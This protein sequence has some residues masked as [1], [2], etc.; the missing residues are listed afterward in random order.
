MVCYGKFSPGFNLYFQLMLLLVFEY[1]TSGCDTLMSNRTNILRDR[2]H[3]VRL[4]LSLVHKYL[5]EQ[6]KISGDFFPLEI[7][8]P[9]LTSIATLVAVTLPKH[10]P[11]SDSTLSSISTQNRVISYCNKKNTNRYLTSTKIV[12]FNHAWSKKK[13]D[14]FDF[15]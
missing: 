1:D 12:N 3:S 6:K 15:R 14:C 10:W 2:K 7:T 11:S 8:S 13:L 5:T 4:T 9:K